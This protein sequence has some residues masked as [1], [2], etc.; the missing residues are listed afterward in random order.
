VKTNYLQS[1][2]LFLPAVVWMG[3]LFFLSHQPALPSFDV[4]LWDFLFRKS[5]HV[6]VYGV[7]FLTWWWAFRKIE[8]RDKIRIGCKWWLILLFCFIY[9]CLDEFHQFFI[10]GRTAA[11]YDVG[12]DVLGSVIACL[13][14]YR[15]I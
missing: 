5:A 9:A 2:L 3:F 11:L 10:P 7:L 14:V 15:V 12:L 8:K 4:I 1:A 6:F 13:Y